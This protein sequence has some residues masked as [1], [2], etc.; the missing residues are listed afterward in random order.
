[1]RKR[2][3]SWLILWSQ[4]YPDTETQQR[5]YKGINR[6]ISFINTDA[7]I[8]SKIVSSQI[9]QYIERI[10]HHDQVGFIWGV[11]DWFNTPNQWN[12]GQTPHDLIKWWG[13][14]I[15]KIQHAFVILGIESNFL[16]LWKGT[17]ENPTANI[18]PDGERLNAF[19][20]RAGTRRVSTPTASVQH[21]A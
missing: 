19:R 17:Y 15:E 11:Q 16:N 7:K 1:M 2:H 3:T 9:Q 20:L 4:N 21:C 5:Y 13:K 6:L 12:K 10:I 14:T 18:V 8:F